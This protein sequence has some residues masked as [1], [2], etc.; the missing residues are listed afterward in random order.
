MNVPPAT[1]TPDQA[2]KGPSVEEIISGTRCSPFT[3]KEFE[4]FLIHEEHSEENLQFQVWY[5]DYRR[6]FEALAPEYQA[7][8]EPPIERYV[9]FGTPSVHTA[10]SIKGKDDDGWWSKLVRRRSSAGASLRS[11]VVNLELTDDEKAI[12]G[13][14]LDIGATKSATALVDNAE[15]VGEKDSDNISLHSACN[16]DSPKFSES[17]AFPTTAKAAPT[18]A[19]SR[20]GSTLSDGGS[21]I[22]TENMERKMKKFPNLRFANLT[23]LTSRKTR[24]LPADTP[25]PFIDEIKLVM[26][27]FILPGSSKEL[28]IDSRLRKHIL[29]SLQ[30]LNEDGSKGEPITTHPDVMK[31]AADHC[32]LMMERSMPH[33][34]QWAKGNVNT[35]KM[36]FWYGVGFT[37]FMI[38]VMIA[39]V[40]MFRVHN[41]YWRIF[42][43][44]FIQF[45]TMQFY[46]A[47]RYFCSQVHGRTARQ[48]YPW[49]LTSEL[50][51]SSTMAPAFVTPAKTEDKATADLK[52]SLPFLFEDE[53]A[54]K[55]STEST[56]VD[57]GKPSSLKPK[58]RSLFRPKWKGAF[59][60]ENGE[61]VP[62]F[63]P[64]RVVEDP[65]IKD[66]H[67]K[68]I[69]EILII[70]AVVTLI[71]EIGIVACPQQHV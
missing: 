53:P 21:S 17:T 69:R 19:F 15:P 33:Y 62:V 66:V 10:S 12:D 7:L 57:I 2:L 31:D 22:N 43:F 24:E 54:V 16:P 65:Y 28:N 18:P 58:I 35:P 52:A 45:G 60:K 56:V 27:T 5:R 13:L 47:S 36:L 68:Q 64:E 40:I 67:N 14:G 20:I 44:L 25:L 55:T 51:T 11:S 30:P 8:S 70:G 4:G 1:P 37:D 63:G 34:M 3:L 38:G 61:R 29:K 59:R 48:L 71:F 46:S 9:P 41:R 39:L 49:E 50:E 6:R 23:P 42:S 32:F 26:T